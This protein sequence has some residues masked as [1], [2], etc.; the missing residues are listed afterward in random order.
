[1][2]TRYDELNV[3][4]TDIGCNRYDDK[5]QDRY[6]LTLKDIIG[7]VEYGCLEVKA[8]SMVKYFPWELEEMITHWKSELKKMK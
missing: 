5:H 7:E 2:G 8:K 1:M 6:E 4:P 3:W